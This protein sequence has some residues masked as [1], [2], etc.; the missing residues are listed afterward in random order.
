MKSKD[1]LYLRDIIAYQIAVKL[2]LNSWKIY[3]RL[4]FNDRAI[5]GN[6]FIR[7][8]D[9]IG[10]NLA[11]GYGR[12]HYLDRIKFYYNSRG[13]ALE[14]KH[15]VFLLKQRDYIDQEEYLKLISDLN[16]FHKQI[17]IYIK[18]CYP[19]KIEKNSI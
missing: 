1:I 6:Q 10:A 15:W 3:K 12:Y 19:K 11:E 7:S 16:E 18:S 13:S 4:N 14:A 5:I 2:S 17:N 8:I 9:S